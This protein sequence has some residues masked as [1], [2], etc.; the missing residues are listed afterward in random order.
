MEARALES[1]V[2]WS[3]LKEQATA[4]RAATIQ[5]REAQL[6]QALQ[7]EVA[8]FARECFRNM[9]LCPDCVLPAACGGRAYPPPI[10]SV[11]LGVRGV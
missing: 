10:A 6:K 8:T 11:S 2:R 3:A 4:R 1:Q 7:D 5:Q 9:P